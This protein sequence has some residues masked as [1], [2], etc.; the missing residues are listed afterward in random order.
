[1]NNDEDN[2]Y[3]SKKHL[4]SAIK[5]D[6]RILPEINVDV[7][8]LNKVL[9]IAPISHVS[10]I[11]S[12][13]LSPDLSSFE[14]CDTNTTAIYSSL[15]SP[16]NA[17]FDNNLKEFKGIKVFSKDRQAHIAS[18]YASDLSLYIDDTDDEKENTN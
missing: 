7:K 13:N 8:I 6:I 15:T 4:Y 11:N 10:T 16:S 2:F 17:K 12:F 1:M 18:Y 5:T 14:S 9:P 3:Y